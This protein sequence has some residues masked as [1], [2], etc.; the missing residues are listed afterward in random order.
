M[1]FTTS[2]AALA[3]ALA[4][5]SAHAADEKKKDDAAAATAPVPPPNVSVT[6]H[7][8]SFGGQSIAYT[9]TTGETYLTDKDDKPVAA[10]FA[11]S[12][13]KDGGDPKTRPITFLYNGGPGSGSLWLHMGAFGPKRV[14]LPDARDDGAPPYPVIDNPE[15]LLDVT[16]LVFIDPVGTGFSHTLGGK[17]PKDYWGVSADAKSIAEFIRI[18]LNENGRWA[19]PKYI[20]GESYGTTRSIALIN[21]LEGS[22]NDVAVNGII[23]ISTILD[24]GAAAEAQGNEMPYI[25]NLPSMATTAWYH[26]KIANPPATVAEVAAQARAFAIGPYAAALLKG[27]QLGA[28]ERA[29]VRAELAR[30]TG[31]S[32]AFVDNANLRVSPGRFYKELLRDR[33]QVI[34]RLDTRYT[35]VDYDK[36]GEEPDNDPSF[37]GIDAAYTSAINSYVRGDLKLKTDRHYVTIGGVNSWDWKLADQRGRDGEVYVNV[38]PYLGKALRE[39]SGLRVFVGQGWYDFATPFFGAEY[40]LNRPGFDPSR[41]SFHY[42]D[43]GHMMYVRPDDLRKLSADVRA[44]IRER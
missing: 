27:N 9:A 39:N 28:E 24:F 13:V 12:Y 42:Y 20:G 25:L 29:S 2:L 38:A 8:G 33:G 15:S 36:A 14:V 35:G 23:L 3:L 40:S 18:W 1:R 43:A 21:E 19:S 41:I 16:D 11:T 44:F 31:L 10:I 30:L 34:G 7:K 6:K 22:Y 4:P 5:L 37:Y 26:H 32:E 17:D